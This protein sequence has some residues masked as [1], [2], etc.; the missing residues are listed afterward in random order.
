MMPIYSRDLVWAENVFVSQHPLVMHK[1]VLMRSKLT[2]SKKF[3]TLLREISLLLF[4]EATQDLPVAPLTVQTPFASC[5]GYE[6]SVRIGLMPILRSGIGMS[7]PILDILPSVPVWHVGIYR[8]PET[9]ESLMY[10]EH[11][12]NNSDVDVSIVMDPMLATGE[13]AIEAIDLLKAHWRKSQVKFMGIVGAPEGITALLRAHPSVSI[14]LAAIDSH[15]NEDGFIVP[16][17]GHA[18]DRQYNT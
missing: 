1:L 12:P 18:G 2:E 9:L 7:E 13:T 16:G 8:D 3:R 6:I 14:Y 5:T 11:A 15:V 17:L 10:C 4:Y